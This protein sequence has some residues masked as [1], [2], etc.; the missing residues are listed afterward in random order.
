[1]GFGYLFLGYFFILNL[2]LR[3][4][5]ILPDIVGC[6][7]MLAAFRRLTKYCPDNRHLKNANLVLMLY[8]LMSALLLVYQAVGLFVE[9]PES[10]VGLIY[11]PF[12]I[13]YSLVIG[14]YHLFMLLGIHSLAGQVGL[15]KLAAR[16]VRM[17]TLTAVYYLFEL[18]SYCGVLEYIAGLT[19][20]PAVV[21]SYVNL[22]LYLLGVLWMLLIWA[23]IFTCYMRIC[24]EGDEDMPYH[25]DI[26]DAIGR[27][28]R[29]KKK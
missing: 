2:P 27:H 13:V 15:D 7:L 9:I 6:L 29:D 18:L 14:A 26:Y 5:D 8:A 28:M 25:E 12:S 22:A 4:F 11:T 21:L 10:F 19:G 17:L 24:L 3:G 1:M 20:Q 23:L 16:S